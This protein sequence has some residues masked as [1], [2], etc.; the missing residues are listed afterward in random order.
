[1][2]TTA[3]RKRQSF[4]LQ[5]A[6][7]LLHGASLEITSSFISFVRSPIT[8]ADILNAHRLRPPKLGNSNP[9]FARCELL[10]ISYG[11]YCDILINYL[12]ILGGAFSR[13]PLYLYT[14]SPTAALRTKRSSSPQQQQRVWTVIKNGTKRVCGDL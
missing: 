10:R 8:P 7:L 11:S 2:P 14:V 1:L 9:E 6:A 3:E 12:S 4:T 5:T 13:I